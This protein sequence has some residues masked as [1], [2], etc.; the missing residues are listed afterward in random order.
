MGSPRLKRGLGGLPFF[1]TNFTDI[2]NHIHMTTKEE[3]LNWI[4]ELFEQPIGELTP[5]SLRENIPIWDSL[6][7][8]TLM[9]DL[10]EKYDIMLSDVE[11]RDMTRV[12]DILDVL[13]REGKLQ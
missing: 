1:F 2:T 8:L 3:A 11:L 9:A 4:A 12:G 7:T 5:E 13:Q 10:D 6:G